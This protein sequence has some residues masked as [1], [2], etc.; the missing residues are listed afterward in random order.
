ME[1]SYLIGS[2]GLRLGLIDDVSVTYSE[3]YRIL[4]G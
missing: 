1:W 2:Q 3:L 4:I